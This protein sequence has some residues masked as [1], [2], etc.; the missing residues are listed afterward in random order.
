MNDNDAQALNFLRDAFPELFGILAHMN[1][2]HL[3]I[4]EVGEIIHRL[5]IVRT[6][7]EGYGKILVEMK[8]NGETGNWMRI[9]TI[10]D[11]V[12]VTLPEET[13]MIE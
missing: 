2:G 4:D 7:D 6:S 10:Q 3:T 11:K 9:R 1:K 5:S 12:L 13:D 8:R